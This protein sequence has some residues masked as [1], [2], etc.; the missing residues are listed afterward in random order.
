[1]LG[2][3]PLV[4][5]DA[6]VDDTPGAAGGGAPGD[7]GDEDCP[8]I[9]LPVVAVC[10]D[11][12]VAVPAQVG[13]DLPDFGGHVTPGTVRLRCGGPRGSRRC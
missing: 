5:A 6:R 11:E 10:L 12:S 13:E 3:L 1:M 4:T 9:H 8:V 2:F 7:G